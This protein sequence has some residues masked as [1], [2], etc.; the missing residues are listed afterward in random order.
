MTPSTIQNCSIFFPFKILILNNFDQLSKE[1]Q[2]SLQTIM[3]KYSTVCRLIICCK[4]VSKIIEHIYSRC[5][6][7]RVPATKQKDIS[8]LLRSISIKEK[9]HLPRQL[10]ESIAYFSNRNL[11]KAILMFQTSTLLNYPFCKA[12]KIL[13]SEWE[14]QIQEIANDVFLKQTPK[15]LHLVRGKL[16]DILKNSIPTE[17]IIRQLLQIILPKFNGQYKF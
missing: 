10:A 12:T 5:I 15:Q 17:I 16:Y 9:I 1:A 13:Y 7:I 8:L 11:R 2:H 6:V 4:N 14:V 3:E